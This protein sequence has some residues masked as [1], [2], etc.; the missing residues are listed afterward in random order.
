MHVQKLGNGLLIDLSHST[1]PPQSLPFTHHVTQTHGD[2]TAMLLAHERNI[3]MVNAR[4]AAA[5]PQAKLG[6]EPK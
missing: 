2:L 6:H 3:E 4:L 1:P 5:A